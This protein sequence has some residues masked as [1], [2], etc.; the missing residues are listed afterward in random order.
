MLFPPCPRVFTRIALSWMAPLLTFCLGLNTISSGPHFTSLS[1]ILYLF[2]MHFSTIYNYTH[3]N[4]CTVSFQTVIKSPLFFP[5]SRTMPGTA[6]PN[7]HLFKN[8][9]V[10]TSLCREFDLNKQPR[11][12][13]ILWDFIILCQA[14]LPTFSL[15][16]P[17]TH[18]NPEKW[19]WYSYRCKNHYSVEW[20]IMTPSRFQLLQNFQL[21]VIFPMAALDVPPRAPRIVFKITDHMFKQIVIIMIFSVF[22]HPEAHTKMMT[23]L[24]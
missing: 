4:V 20:L 21:P 8:I 24:F 18:L 10:N 1:T 13:E 12:N 14:T 15:L 2:L 3:T 22:H 16:Q 19:L 9:W 6:G 5:T 23:S 17:N 11:N 7:P